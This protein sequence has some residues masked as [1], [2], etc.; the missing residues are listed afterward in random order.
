MPPCRPESAGGDGGI[1]L[2]QYQQAPAPGTHPQQPAG[3]FRRPPAG[4]FRKT[5]DQNP[6]RQ[7]P[8]HPYLQVDA[9][10]ATVRPRRDPRKFRHERRPSGG[11]ILRRIRQ[12][13]PTGSGRAEKPG[14]GR[15][16]GQ[17]KSPAD[18]R[19]PGHAPPLGS[20]RPRSARPVGND[21]RLGVRRFCP[22]VPPAG[23]GVRQELLRERH[24][25]ARKGHRGGRIEER[26]ILP[27]G[28]RLGL[29]RPDGRRTG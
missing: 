6:D 27:P 1:L 23:C 25:P 13:L 8:R 7:R 18:A 28:R 9:R 3:I 4:G 2:A 29:D 17:E 5:G 24:L 10:L 21:E 11:K 14:Y 20:P 26:R 15:G 16:G 22:D 12:G 19:R